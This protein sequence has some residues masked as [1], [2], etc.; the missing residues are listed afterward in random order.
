MCFFSTKKVKETE[1]EV[2]LSADKERVAEFSRRYLQIMPEKYIM[3]REV[4]EDTDD[5]LHFRIV[6]GA[7]GRPVSD[8]ELT[9][10]YTT[11][12][13]FGTKLCLHMVGSGV[14]NN[15]KQLLKA[16]IKEFGEMK[17]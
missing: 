9:A 8:F 3:S 10:R 16:Y 6:V 12:E 15:T 5:V 14:I 4:Y 1:G 7:N 13:G 11:L 17:Q 2:C